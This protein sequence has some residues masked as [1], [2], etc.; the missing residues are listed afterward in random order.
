M[1]D[2]TGTHG[3]A[4]ART[5]RRGT[6]LVP[7]LVAAVAVAAL[8]GCTGGPP[9]PDAPAATRDVG[10]QAFQW[11]WDALAEE[12]RASIGPAGYAWVLTS[13]PQEHVLG[14]QWWTAYQPVSYRV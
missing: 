8:A 6:G 13:P 11:T 5:R 2:G 14:P 10:V 12:C 4:R 3:R 7:A 9:A 1:T